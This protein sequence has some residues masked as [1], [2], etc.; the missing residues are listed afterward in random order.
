MS[1]LFDEIE[2]LI[3]EDRLDEMERKALRAIPG[4][5]EEERQDLYRYIAWAR[6]ETGRAREAL[7]AA[8]AGED[9]L[10]EAKALF[11]LWRMDEA[12][13]LLDSF[14][15]EGDD[16]AEAAFYRGLVEEFRGGDPG[17]HFRRA[18]KLD[19]GRFPLP[20]RLDDAAIDEV[21]RGALGKLPPPVARE[22]ERAAVEVIDRPRPDPDVDPLSLGLYMGRSAL[23]EA[24][25]ALPEHPP[26]IEIY[27]RNIERIARDREEAVEELRITLLHEIG[28]H[29]GYDEEG[30][31]GLGLA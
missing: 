22:M 23:E 24:H 6:I 4:A 26:R 25:D 27:R 7:E 5:D 29:L 20:P 8:R 19:A 11:H 10:Y 12:A 18:A 1:D 3:D 9:A 13:R 30:V 15:A 28:H 14:R 2:A 21:V 31:E 16:A 17:P